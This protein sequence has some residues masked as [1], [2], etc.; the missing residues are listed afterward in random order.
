[1][2]FGEWIKR[3]RLQQPQRMSQQALA[4]AI[5]VSKGYI[6][7]IETD[8][9]AS[10]GLP[11]RVS[12]HHLR[13]LAKVFNVSE[14]EMFSRAT[15][16]VPEGYI[17]VGHNEALSD[18]AAALIR[19]KLAAYNG[20]GKLGLSEM[21]DLSSEIDDFAQIRVERMMRQYQ[22]QA[23]SGGEQVQKQKQGVA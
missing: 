10:T 6:S 23:Q 1:M 21:D 19:K 17:I 14:Q 12:D 3:L 15:A 20:E 16:V 18:P 13:S 11:P 5:G 22:Y 8:N 7:Q 4:D 9:S 2:T